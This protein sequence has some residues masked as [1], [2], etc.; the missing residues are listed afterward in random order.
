MTSQTG[1]L[2]TPWSD[3]RVSLPRHLYVHV[4]LCSSRC[5]Y[6]DFFSTVD[7]GLPE[8]A[9]VVGHTVALLRGWLTPQVRW[10]ALETLYIG[11][12]TPTVLGPHLVQLIR[13]LTALIPLASE[14][15]VTVEANPESFTP[16]LASALAAEGVTRVS[17]GVQSLD[18]S[19]LV[20]LGR[21]HD[22]AT[23]LAAITAGVDAGLDVSA[24]LIC[25][26]PG[27]SAEAWE[28]SLR[29]VVEAGVSH[30]SVY[31][32]TVEAATPLARAIEAG[33]TLAPDEDAVVDG[34][35]AAAAVLGELGFDRYEVANYARPGHRSLHN[36]AYWTGK[37]YIGIGGGAHGMVDGAQARALGLAPEEG[38]DIG[39]AR[40]AYAAH[41][42]P[43]DQLQPLSSIEHLTVAEAAREDA[44]L[45]MRMSEG[46]SE[47]LAVR[48]RVTPAL[49]SLVADGLVTFADGRWRP[50]ERG[51][52]FGNE[53]FSRIWGVVG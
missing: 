8:H 53:V 4:P 38:G 24:D 16:A 13:S 31:P 50:T 3:T 34:M 2:V 21:C 45:G 18:D 20:G 47:G 1:D 49:E 10:S 42:L 26:V 46:I 43:G 35:H 25:G 17:I 39:R 30:V 15:E 12:G 51:W 36:T 48:A 41:V 33:E 27:V 40:Y 29:G 6:C 28:R 19:A 11:G 9:A 22:S 52:L 37:P 44:M 32:L 14:A 5:S 23:A 7:D